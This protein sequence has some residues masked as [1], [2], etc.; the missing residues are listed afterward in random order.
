ME[1]LNCRESVKKCI[2]SWKKYNP[3]YQIIQW[4]ESNYDY[5]QNEYMLQAYKAGKYG[6]VPDYARLDI[7]YQYGGIYLDTDVEIIKSWDS[8]LESPIFFGREGDFV[9]PG[10]GFGAIA[11]APIIR[12]LRD[13]Y[14]TIN[15][16]NKDGSYNLKPS[17]R[18][19]TEYL[20]KKG[21]LRNDI[22]Q[23]LGEITI[24][25]SEYFCPKDILGTKNN[26]TENT[27]SIHHYDASWWGEE[28][29][30]NFEKQKEM[31]EKGL[32]IWRIWNGFRVLKNEGIFEL[33]KKIMHM[34]K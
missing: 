33:G 19:V 28:E 31:R 17:P 29:K 20:L 5:T 22:K 15:F 10:L 30:R 21:M 11:Q 8:I 18:Y 9:S 6:F 32:W 16:I 24:Y 4:D 23:Q 26:I 2:A 34:K 1:E 27:L 14:E 13:Q 25:P 7:I 3:D 12:E